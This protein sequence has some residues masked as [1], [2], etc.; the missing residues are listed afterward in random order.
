[1]AE[2]LREVHSKRAVTEIETLAPGVQEAMRLAMQLCGQ[3]KSDLDDALA[4]VRDAR[5]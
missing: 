1:M 5:E 2:Q 3:D 4:M